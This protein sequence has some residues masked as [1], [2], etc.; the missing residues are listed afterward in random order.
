LRLL[1][2]LLGV[3]LHLAGCA[4]PDV[5]GR[6]ELARQQAEER[7]WSEHIIDAG[8]FSLAVWTGPSTGAAILTVY[9]EGDGFAWATPSKPS[10]NPTPKNPVGLALALAHPAAAGS[11]AAYVARP[12]QYVDLEQEEAC[13]PRAW[14]RDRF[15]ETVVGAINE[16]V[17]VVKLRS[18]ADRVELVGYSG[19]GAVAALVASRRDDVVRFV[20]IAAPLDHGLW[21]RSR[22]LTPLYGSL[23]PVD[24]AAALGSLTQLHYVGAED[25]VIGSDLAESFRSRQPSA[26][27]VRIV[28]VP[29][30]DHR[31][32]WADAWEDLYQEP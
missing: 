32:C 22:G 14:T 15:S 21:T 26:A 17:T 19:G 6:K 30:F 5:S 8:D 7:G 31:C 24:I 25:P 20:S 9:L 4:A 16:A 28:V 18:G 11:D 23:D 2:A 27:P 12:C 1:P 3:L 29:G 10:F 13:E